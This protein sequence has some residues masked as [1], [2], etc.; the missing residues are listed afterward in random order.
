ML[1][2]S[3]CYY[4]GKNK[5]TNI[6]NHVDAFSKIKKNGDLFI[7]NTMIDSK[8][9][10]VHEEIKKTL[11]S[12]I[13]SILDSSFV[14]LTSF[15]WGGTIVGLWM[16][17]NYG[18]VNNLNAYIAHFEEDFG[19]GNNKWLID[20]IKLLDDNTYQVGESNIGRIKRENDDNRIKDSNSYQNSVR[21]GNP[22]VWSD[23]GYYFSTIAK[24]K[25]VESKIGIFHKGD[26]LVRYNYIKDGIDL[27]EV[28]YPTLL[29]HANLKFKVLN[30]HDY[31]INEW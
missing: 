19:P 24:L 9:Q 21:L 31:F 13:T 22:E 3:I 6:K 8:E 26:P 4:Y 7:L 16:T 2:Y 27:G 18:K 15:N 23:G 28:G 5:K 11:C 10:C 25:I 12:F 14:I 17:Y 20:S 1:L 30:R 29:Y